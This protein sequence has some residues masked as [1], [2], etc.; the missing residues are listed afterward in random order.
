MRRG[1]RVLISAAL[2]VLLARGGSGG[3]SRDRHI[4]ARP[5]RQGLG[6]KWRQSDQSALFHAETDRR[7]QRQATQGR[8]D[9]PSEGLR[10]RRQV[11]VRSDAAR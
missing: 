6:D 7:Q 8:L 4:A 11:F 1:Q 10:V 9:D 2:G 3:G 5:G